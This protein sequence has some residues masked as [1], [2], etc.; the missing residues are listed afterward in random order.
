MLKKT[1]AAAFAAALLL[2]G[3]ASAASATTYTPDDNI[4]VS[5]ATPS[6]GESV[7]ITVTGIP[8]SVNSVIF[9][10][11]S[12]S[13]TLG[14]LVRTAAVTSSVTKPVT[15]D[16]TSSAT[17]TFSQAGTF[18]VTATGDDGTD[19]GSTTLVVAAAT[20]G[21]GSG[22]G[23]DDGGL[24]VTGGSVPIAALWIGAG[25]LGLGA[26]AFVAATARRRAQQR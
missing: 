25:A 14:S 6:P 5:D 4:A 21:S 19:L 1:L 10:T 17:A 20:D 2:F 12:S 18:V 24:A 23:D 8:G 15:A 13:V 22:T 3:G 16:R 9:S 11:T 26:L 7:T